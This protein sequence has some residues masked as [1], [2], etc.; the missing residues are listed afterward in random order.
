MDQPFGSLGMGLSTGPVIVLCISTIVV[1][2]L[3]FAPN[4]GLLWNWLQQTRNRRRL[5]TEQ[6]LSNLYHMAAQHEEATHPHSVSALRVMG[7]APSVI[8]QSLHVLAERGLVRQV[9]GDQWA[10]TPT[11]VNA[12][13]RMQHQG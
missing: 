1:V 11:G 4:R 7:A 3:L 5:Q 2:S 6:V 8:Q 13:Q 10:L 9:D 12:A